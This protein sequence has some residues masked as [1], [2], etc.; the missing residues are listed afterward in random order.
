MAPMFLCR[1]TERF[2]AFVSGILLHLGMED[3][4]AGL[5]S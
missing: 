2:F 5:I 3:G 1:W 4:A